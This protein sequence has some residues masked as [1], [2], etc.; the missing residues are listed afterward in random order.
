MSTVNPD[1]TALPEQYAILPT[2]GHIISVIGNSV[3][4]FRVAVVSYL[5]KGR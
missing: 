3:P 5:F 2:I 1:H 4:K